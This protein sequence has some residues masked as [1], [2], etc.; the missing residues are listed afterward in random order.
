MIHPFAGTEA[1]FIGWLKCGF[2][3]GGR[4]TGRHNF[5][6]QDAG[7]LREHETEWEEARHRLMLLERGMAI[8]AS[9]EQMGLKRL[10]F[11]SFQRSNGV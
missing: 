4:S 8:R 3:G 7:R 1:R 6:F 5:R 9:G 2:C 10:T 11:S